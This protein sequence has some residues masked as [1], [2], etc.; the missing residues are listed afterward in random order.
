MWEWSQGGDR[1]DTKVPPHFWKVMVSVPSVLV[2]LWL[3][4]V[5]NVTVIGYSP[6]VENCIAVVAG[7]VN[8]IAGYVW[9]APDRSV[10]GEQ[11]G[12]TC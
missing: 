8:C 12:E 4:F 3:G 1:R 9:V 10:L 2:T 5:P 11:L 6:A 7:V